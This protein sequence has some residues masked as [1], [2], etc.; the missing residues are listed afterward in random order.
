MCKGRDDLARARADREGEADR[1]R[2]G[3]RARKS[4]RS[5]RRCAPPKPTSPSSRPSCARRGSARTRS[6]PGSRAPR[7]RCGCAKCMPAAGSRRPSPIST[8][9]SVKPTLAEGQAEA[10]MLAAPPRTLEEE[11]AEL[12]VAER[13]DA[14]LEAMKAAR[15]TRHDPPHRRHR[16]RRSAI[17][18]ASVVGSIVGDAGRRPARLSDGAAAAPRAARR[19]P[20]PSRRC[21]RSRGDAAAGRPDGARLEVL[22]RAPSPPEPTAGEQRILEAAER[23]GIREEKMNM[24]GRGSRSI[25]R[26]ASCSASAPGIANHTGRR[27]DHRPHRP[28]A[29]HPA[30]RLP[31]DFDRLW[32]R[33]IRRP[34]AAP[35]VAALAGVAGRARNRASG[36]AASISGCRRS[37]P[38]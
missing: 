14:E 15:R 18:I 13:V 32:R 24:R 37:R 12:K 27:R 3:A 19:A 38:T 31:V 30:G 21:G 16:Y 17:E 28:G 23:P 29:G 11:I 6:R 33:R 10:L 1:P 20:S 35:P 2:R 25:G 26:T 22:E 8:C 9:S 34:A 4:P 36:C 5:T 7:T